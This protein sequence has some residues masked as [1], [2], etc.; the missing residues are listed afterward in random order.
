[1]LFSIDLFKIFLK[2]CKQHQNSELKPKNETHHTGPL[3]Q[4]DA[5]VI[6]TWGSSN[7]IVL[8]NHV[9]VDNPFF[10]FNLFQYNKRCC[11]DLVVK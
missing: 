7:G 2:L 8:E 4:N 3:C 10:D 1:M 9:K 11:S 5:V 6:G